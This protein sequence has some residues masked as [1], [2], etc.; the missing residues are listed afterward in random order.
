MIAIE[1]HQPPPIALVGAAFGSR[2]REPRQLV[3]FL[4]MRAARGALRRLVVMSLRLGGRAAAVRQSQHLEFGDHPLQGQAE[5]ITDAH[6]MSGLHPLG[7][8]MNLAPVDG[9]GG[10]GTG[11]VKSRVPQPLVQTAVFRVLLR[12]HACTIA[13]PLRGLAV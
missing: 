6:A 5:P 10:Q 13:F 11:F 8:Q 4:Q 7:V 2:P 1:A 3:L 12:P 9:R